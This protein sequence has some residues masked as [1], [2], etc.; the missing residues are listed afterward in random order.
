[1]KIKSNNSNLPILPSF[2]SPSH[3]Y[4]EFGPLVL[5]NTKIK[6]LPK[7]NWNIHTELA[8]KLVAEY[9][10]WK[11]SHIDNTLLTGKVFLHM[12]TIMQ[13]PWFHAHKTVW[14]WDREK[15]F[16]LAM[17]DGCLKSFVDFYVA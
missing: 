15:Y 4:E 3:L 1:M 14:L 8:L 7:S 10:T 6:A 5:A 9:Q 16:E 17:F 12:G 2:S 11:I 13:G